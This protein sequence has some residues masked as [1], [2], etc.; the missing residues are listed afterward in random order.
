MI[1]VARYPFP[2]GYVLDCSRC[3]RTRGV[4]PSLFPAR[5]AHACGPFTAAELEDLADGMADGPEITVTPD[6]EGYRPLT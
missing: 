2:G 6:P 1:R 5:I 4:H 3:G